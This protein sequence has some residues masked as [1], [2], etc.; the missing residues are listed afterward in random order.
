M[1]AQTEKKYYSNTTN[2]KETGNL[3]NGLKDG[4][5]K[6]YYENGKLETI[7]NYIDGE[8]KGEWKVYFDNEQLAAIGNYASTKFPTPGTWTFYTKDGIAEV[9]DCPEP[10]KGQFLGACH[11]IYE[12]QMAV[13]PKSGVSYGY[14]ES[15]WEMSCAVPGQDIIESAKPKIQLMWNKY[16][17]FLRCYNYPNYISSEKNIT[18]FCLDTGFTAFLTEAVKRYDLDINFIDPGDNKTTL[19]FIKEQEEYIRSSPPVDTSRADEYKRIYKLLRD[20]G[21]K[22]ASEI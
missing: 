19:D 1:S 12:K 13:I 9:F 4:I 5:W 11:A 8:K 17:I 7:G 10:T 2:L 20:K 16:R 15:I 18:K 21:A 14:Q 3:K 6:T 22:H